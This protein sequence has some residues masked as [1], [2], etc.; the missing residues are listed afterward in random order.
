MV[1]SSKQN[2]LREIIK[3]SN[4][5]MQQFDI[6]DACSSEKED[7]GSWDPP[8]R[9]S[10]PLV[11]A[12]DRSFRHLNLSLHMKR[13]YEEKFTEVSDQLH[14]LCL[15]EVVKI[16]SSLHGKLHN[17]DFEKIV[18]ITET[19]LSENVSQLHSS[20]MATIQNKIK[21]FHADAAF[22]DVESSGESSVAQKGHSRRAVAILEK[23]FSQ[24]TNINKSE[25]LQLAKATN[26]EPRQV[27]IWFQNRR[28]RKPTAQAH[29][30]TKSQKQSS[31]SLP[32]RRKRK[33]DE[34]DGIVPSTPKHRRRMSDSGMSPGLS[35]DVTPFSISSRGRSSSVDL[36]EAGHAMSSGTSYDDSFSAYQ[37]I[38]V[39]P[40]RST[41]GASSFDEQIVRFTNAKNSG[42]SSNSSSNGN[43]RN[44]S[45]TSNEMMFNENG[46]LLLDWDDLELNLD[47]FTG[48]QSLTPLTDNQNNGI[49]AGLDLPNSAHSTQET[50]DLV[51]IFARKLVEE[52]F[53]P[54]EFL[55]Q[56]QQSE[57][58]SSPV[59]GRLF[60]ARGQEQDA[61][62][63]ADL[64]STQNSGPS[65]S[66]STQTS[67]GS[68]TPRSLFN[69]DFDNL[70]LEDA[71]T[72]NNES[73]GQQINSIDLH[74]MEELLKYE[75]LT[76]DMLGLIF[77]P[78]ASASPIANVD[79]A[80]LTLLN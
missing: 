38:S 2:D 19:S 4:A 49:L 23:V 61:I 51:S 47:D 37:S 57:E 16:A 53:N 78:P 56:M 21:A 58:W 75:P 52:S 68:S 5:L 33:S 20:M 39:S 1:D 73:I 36:F 24:T 34:M 40:P 12:F 22:S 10:Y 64:Q 30:N 70:G 44:S 76:T 13:R 35:R 54:E 50:N 46:E 27:T 7:K 79:T 32:L 25:K 8:K 45:N 11:N 66:T 42:S 72:Y 3:V 9:L 74:A 26:L 63:L 67:P 29:S 41:F 28:N 59:M 77:S 15:A 31:S 17:C 55:A 48:T 14:S 62:S 60:L 18:R 80:S 65:A 69:F 43:S 71:M 6:T